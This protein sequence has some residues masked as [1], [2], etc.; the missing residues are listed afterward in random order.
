MLQNL[1]GIFCEWRR[2]TIDDFNFLQ[3]EKKNSEKKIQFSWRLTQAHTRRFTS[4]LQHMNN[5]KITNSIFCKLKMIKHVNSSFC[6][7][8]KLIKQA[9]SAC[10]P[11]LEKHFIEKN[12]CTIWG[13]KILDWC[14]M[15]YLACK[16]LSDFFLNFFIAC[17]KKLKLCSIVKKK[18][19]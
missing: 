9:K 14:L 7:L 18:D 10:R 12:F 5:A 19:L 17:N 2:L 1:H 6:K 11:F 13:C 4:L 8:N 16:R 3:S 15:N